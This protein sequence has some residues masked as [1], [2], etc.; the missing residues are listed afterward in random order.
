MIVENSAV[1]EIIRAYI[2][3]KIRNDNFVTKPKKSQITW[4]N[5]NTMQNVINFHETIELFTG[6][7]GF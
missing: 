4:Q 5:G 7:K 6:R 1:N 3:I 2:F